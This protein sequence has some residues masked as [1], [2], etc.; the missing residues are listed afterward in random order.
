MRRQ[1]VER[2]WD[3]KGNQGMDSRSD[4]QGGRTLPQPGKRKALQKVGV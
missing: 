1:T 2:N 4:A 3:K